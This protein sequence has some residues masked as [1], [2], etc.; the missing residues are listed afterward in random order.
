MFGAEVLRKWSGKNIIGPVF[1]SGG[2]VAS[3][4]GAN[5]FLLFRYLSLIAVPSCEVDPKRNQFNY[6]LTASD[7]HWL[8][9]F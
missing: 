2:C 6:R 4:H 5:A 8:A 7:R 1:S 9:A 3:N